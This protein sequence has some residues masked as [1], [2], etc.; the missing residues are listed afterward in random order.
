[1]KDWKTTSTG[2]LSILS[3]ILTVAYAI[4]DK[5]LDMTLM[6]SAAT[7]ILAGIGLIWATDTDT[8]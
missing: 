3:G 6:I 8:V 2:I 5:T 7:S 1:M 4:Y